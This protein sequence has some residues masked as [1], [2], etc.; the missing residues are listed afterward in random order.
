VGAG[1]NVEMQ[2][3]DDPDHSTL[4]RVLES[5]FRRI[6][7]DKT[8][9]VLIAIDEVPELLLALSKQEHGGD[10]V[11]HLLHWLRSLR[12]TH[13]QQVRWIFLGSIG[14]D[15]FLD[16]RQIRKT[17]NYLTLLGLDALTNEEAD[18][19]FETLGRDNHLPLSAPVRQ[20]IIAKVGWPLPHHVQI[21]FH[22]LVELN[23][24]AVD[25]AAVDRAF[26]SLL[27]PENLSQFDTWRQRL[28]EQLS[29]SDAA[30]AKTILRHLCQY[31]QGRTRERIL[32]ALMAAPPR[33]PGTVED[34]LAKLLLV[35]QHDGYLLESGGSY[36]FR[37]FLLREFW[38][39]R[40]VR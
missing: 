17:I 40:E 38:H 32:N 22:A 20:H 11:D 5:I 35:L 10:R 27:H 23:V 6:E 25:Q 24:A 14:L 8:K 19:F 37:S 13:R 12:L 28:E 21:M 4:G 33:D 18:R 36:A 15:N 26:E 7:A 2:E 3:V 1:I 34:Q 30:A 16:D 39:R 29:A 31:P 9:K